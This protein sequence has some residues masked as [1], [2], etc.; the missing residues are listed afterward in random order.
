MGLFK[1]DGLV[2]D[3]FLIIAALYIKDIAPGA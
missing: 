3:S 2:I 1:R